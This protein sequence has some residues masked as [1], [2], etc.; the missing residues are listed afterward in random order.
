VATPVLSF[1]LS[2]HLPRRPRL[3]RELVCALP[4]CAFTANWHIPAAALSAVEPDD[5]TMVKAQFAAGAPALFR[6]GEQFSG[7][8]LEVAGQRLGDFGFEETS[9]RRIQ[10]IGEGRLFPSDISR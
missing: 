9:R 2:P 5:D 10:K 7:E 1:G 4:G 3:H 8:L 6:C